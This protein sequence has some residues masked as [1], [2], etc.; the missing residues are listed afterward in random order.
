M[1]IVFGLDTHVKP[2]A[3]ERYVTLARRAGAQPVIILN[4]SDLVEDP[5]AGVADAVTVAGDAPV[6]A[7]SAMDHA[8][9]DRACAVSRTGADAGVARAVRRGEVLPG[10]S[11]LG[12]RGARDGE[13]S[14]NGTRVAAT[15]A[16]IASCW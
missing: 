7:V 4:K 15:Q 6:H 2:R 9:L 8:V 11:T 12:G 16:C 5:A 14:V 13:P 3:L 10:Q 1:L